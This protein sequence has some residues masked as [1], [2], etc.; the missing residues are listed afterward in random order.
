MKNMFHRHNVEMAFACR[1]KLKNFLG[2]TKD[3][4]VPTDK[5]GIYWAEFATCGI[6]V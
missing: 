2:S 1:Q 4:K 3:K 6:Y 5:C